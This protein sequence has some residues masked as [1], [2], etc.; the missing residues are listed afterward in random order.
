M[1]AL[2][3]LGLLAL[4]AGISFLGCALLN[5]CLDF[6]DKRREKQ[7]PKLYKMFEEI[8]EIGSEIC[9]LHNKQILPLKQKIDRILAE[10]PYFSKAEKFLQE[11]ILE[12][13]R[14][15]IHDLTIQERKL[16]AQE[17]EIRKE[18]RKY[19]EDNNLVWAKKLGW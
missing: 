3:I 6:V 19:V 5:T 17:E 16:I 11:R 13:L 14:C 9:V 15:E 10:M 7:H 8:H 4:I 2:I 1:F 18:I 12:S